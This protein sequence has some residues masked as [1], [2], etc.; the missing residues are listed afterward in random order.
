MTGSRRWWNPRMVVAV[1][2]AGVTIFLLALFVDRLFPQLPRAK[3]GAIIGGW[4]IFCF[5]ILPLVN[6]RPRDEPRS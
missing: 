5:C 6:R 4:M 1:L 2:V 3:R